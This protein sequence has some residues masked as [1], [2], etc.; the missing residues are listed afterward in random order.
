MKHRRR[1]KQETSL[2]ER[3]AMHA[4]ECRERAY[5]LPLGMERDVLLKRARQA[6]SAVR[7]NRWISSPRL[8]PPE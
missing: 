1:F 8:Q 5:K 7:I 4:E 3:L 6:D 2:E